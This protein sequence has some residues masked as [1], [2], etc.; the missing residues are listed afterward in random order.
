[1]LKGYVDLSGFQSR[2]YL[3]HV[4]DNAKIGVTN[5]MVRK[6]AG[7]MLD[8]PYEMAVTSIEGAM[9]HMGGYYHPV[10]SLPNQVFY[11]IVY[12]NIPEGYALHMASN[13]IGEGSSSNWLTSNLGTG[14]WQWYIGRTVCGSSGTFRSLGFL[15]LENVAGKDDSVQWRVG[16]SNIFSVTEF[17]E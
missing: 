3:F 16:Y 2:E 13:G 6:S 5:E 14:Q 15:C 17:A 9:L 12:A 7:N 11:Y 8:F 1:N 4:Y 10:Q